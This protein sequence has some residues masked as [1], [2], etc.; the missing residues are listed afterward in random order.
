M[1]ELSMERIEYAIG[2][3]VRLVEIRGVKQTQ[4]EHASGVNQSTISKILS[5]SQDGTADRYTPSEEI[6]RK[7]FQG[8]GLKL[9]DILNETDEIP[10]EILGYLAT[11]LTGLDVKCDNELRRIVA[12][13]QTIA[14]AKEFAAPPFKVYWPGD[15]THPLRHANITADQVYVTDRSRASTYDFIIIFCAAPSYGVGQ[16]NEIATQAGVPA[17]R[18]VP[19]QGMSRMM[20]GS[21]IRAIDIPYAGDLQTGITL[22]HTKI[23]TA[24]QEIRRLHFRHHAFYRGL[25]SDSFGARLRKL[26]DDRCGDHAQFADDLG[27][28]LGYL[29][30]LLDE[31]FAVANPSAR[32]L[33]RMATRL[34]ERVGYL[35]GETD[36][37]DPVWVESHSSWRR[38]IDT[39]PSV[40][41]SVA[42]AIRDEWRTEYAES[43][44]QDEVTA[45]S[46]RKSSILMRETDWDAKYRQAKRRGGP[47]GQASLL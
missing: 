45:A 24:L 16:E 4:L 42:L 6:L 14:T 11:P 47:S 21:F 1:R 36:Q 30:K 18:L 22:D 2:R 5:R 9:S 32:L 29:Q 40:E 19:E 33:R 17:I 35:L 3:L 25:S 38:W 23:V 26:I 37:S 27:I 28:S 8:L 41:A 7:L 39:T 13:V 20:L 44:R 15:H 46:F 31:P 43:K 12:M 10:D 34:G